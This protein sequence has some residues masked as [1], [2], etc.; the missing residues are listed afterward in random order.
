MDEPVEK[1]GLEAMLN[2]AAGGDPIEP[3]VIVPD[4]ITP[5]VVPVENPDN[6]GFDMEGNAFVA[7]EVVVP[8]ED[9]LKPGF[10]T[11]GKPFVAPVVE[12]P[13]TEKPKTNPMKDVRDNLKKEKAQNLLVTNTIKK[14][15][16]GTYEFG[17]KDHIGEDGNI[18][19]AGLAKA[20]E[21]A[22]VAVVAAGKGISPEVQAEIDK[23]EKD[24][25]EIQKERLQISMDKALTNLQIDKTL[26]QGDI[27]NFF[28]DAMAEKKN[29]YQWIA[30]G[31]T[32]DDL[33]SLI[34]ADKIKTDEIA[35]AVA[36]ER[37]KWEAEAV[38]AGKLP[39]GNPG[40]AA[41]P[42]TAAKKDGVT[43]AD[44]KREAAEKFNK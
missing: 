36:A 9:P 13:I 10:D 6:V 5:D 43:L 39:K 16:A 8:V 38:A 23:I 41:K 3:E 34:Y 22:D 30:Q 21:D 31:G 12:K 24:K 4:D 32:L 1:L 37:V 20:M 42:G 11:E 40:L 44:L 26:K 18:D 17:I 19:Y 28:K 7:P 27:N 2:E 33:Y 29:P 25:V 14:L 35:T 15:T